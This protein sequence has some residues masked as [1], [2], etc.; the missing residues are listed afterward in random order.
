MEYEQNRTDL[1]SGKIV[2]NEKC[3][4]EIGKLSSVKNLFWANHASEKAQISPKRKIF[5]WTYVPEKMN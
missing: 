2:V 3:T 5:R 4:P 1:I